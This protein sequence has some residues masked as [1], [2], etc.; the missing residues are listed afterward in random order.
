ML[1]KGRTRET[2]EK[3]EEEVEEEKPLVGPKAGLSLLEQR[4]AMNKA[5]EG[6]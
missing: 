1:K 2:K 3:K 4:A 6:K 5:V